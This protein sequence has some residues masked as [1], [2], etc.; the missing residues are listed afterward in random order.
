MNC[1]ILL[2][3]CC[4]QYVAVTKTRDALPTHRV[5]PFKKTWV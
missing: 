2:I 4:G 1:A 5:G 3:T